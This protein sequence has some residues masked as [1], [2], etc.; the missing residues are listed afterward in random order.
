MHAAREVYPNA[1]VTY[2]FTKRVPL[3]SSTFTKRFL[4]KLKARIKELESLSLSD[5]E[6]KWAKS[7]QLLPTE[8]WD[9]LRTF[10]YKADYVDVKL[11]EDGQLELTIAGPWHETILFEVPLLALISETYFEDIPIKVDLK[12]YKERTY[13]KGLILSENQCLFT[14]FG[15]RRR[16]SYEV[17]QVAIEA[18]MS[19]PQSGSQKS[20]YIGTSNV[21]F[22]KMYGT[23]PIGTMAHEWIMAHA[24]MFGVKGSNAKALEV[25]LKVF[26]DEY[27]IALTD[28]YTRETFFEEFT[29]E[30][31]AKYS[32]LR[33]DSGDPLTF[34]EQALEFYR[35][36]G[37]NAKDKK[38]VFS[39]NLNT[40]RVLEIHKKVN[41][42]FIPIYGIGTNFTNDVIGSPPINMVI[43]MSSING[44]PVYKL[45]DSKLKA[46]ESI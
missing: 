1:K 25:W 13:Q 19:L 10:R 11:S 29:P 28:T 37:I 35:S 44:K 23:P 34:V 33:Q 42:R 14:E 18:F 46:S 31:A 15:T 21:L 27:T 6:W 32:G 45:T 30:L 43:K 5:E 20:S 16:R 40:E 38:V 17:Q 41:K 36:I 39:D 22:S 24:G 12:D 3:D 4:E 2:K 26:G 9:Y 8:F 7:Q